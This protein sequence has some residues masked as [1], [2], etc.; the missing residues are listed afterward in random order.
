MAKRP[1]WAFVEI[2]LEKKDK[3]K[4]DKFAEQYKGNPFEI[5]EDITELGYKV[6]QSYVDKQNSYV[7]SVS[8]SERSGI[9]NY[10]TVTT[11]SSDLREAVEMAGYKVLDLAKN[12]DW[13]EF[14]TEDSNW[15]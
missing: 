13:T 11:W 1:E 2:K 7:V 3:P 15:G 4:V 9:N 12:S 14:A 8:G 6:S 10:Q 5:L